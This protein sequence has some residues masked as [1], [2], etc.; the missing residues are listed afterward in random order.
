MRPA[1]AA[2]GGGVGVTSRP[3]PKAAPSRPQTLQREK[4][5]HLCSLSDLLDGHALET[6]NHRL[7]EDGSL[8]YHT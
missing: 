1:G 3:A 6:K 4:G 8:L 2:E 7:C 5:G